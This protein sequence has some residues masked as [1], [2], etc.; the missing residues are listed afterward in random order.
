M[1]GR[2]GIVIANIQRETQ[3]KLMNALKPV[4]S[5]NW[6]ALVMMG[7]LSKVKIAYK[8]VADIVQD[9]EIF[10]VLNMILHSFQCRYT[11]NLIFFSQRWMML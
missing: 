5:S 10:H 1:V 9:G 3:L 2:G 11:I 4:G 8:A 6:V 7:A